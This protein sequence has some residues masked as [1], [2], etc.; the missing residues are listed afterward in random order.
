MRKSIKIYLSV[1]FLALIIVFIFFITKF[2]KIENGTISEYETKINITEPS[3]TGTYLIQYNTIYS[4]SCKDKTLSKEYNY[5]GIKIAGTDVILP[6]F[7]GCESCITINRELKIFC[8]SLAEIPEETKI[9]ALESY[10]R[11]EKY[12]IEFEEKHLSANYRWFSN[13]TYLSVY[14]ETV[15]YGGMSETNERTSFVFLLSTGE[16]IGIDSFLGFD[17]E[18][19]KETTLSAFKYMIESEKDSFY[20]DAEETMIKLYKKYSFF[21]DENGATFFF[22]PGELAPAHKGYIE[23]IIPI[24]ER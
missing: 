18:K 12:G 22:N 21:I 11:A 9:T 4:V 10:E 15:S 5:N 6:I 16:R 17:S 20:S 7:E 3:I 13:G 19:S 1:F 14:F 24:N 8:D 23:I 2:Q